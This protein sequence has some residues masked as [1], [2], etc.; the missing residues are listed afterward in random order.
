[1][2]KNQQEIAKLQ[3]ELQQKEENYNQVNQRLNQELNEAR[4]IREQNLTKLLQL[5]LD[6]DAEQKQL[7]FEK[8][9]LHLPV[10]E[11]IERDP[12][13]KDAALLI[14]R[15]L[16]QWYLHHRPLQPQI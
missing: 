12:N 8:L 2:H 1:M 6:Y 14:C 15:R 10:L 7:E 3:S 11:R 16:T 13:C 5:Q 4:D 9:G